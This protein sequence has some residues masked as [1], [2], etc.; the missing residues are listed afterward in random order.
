MATFAASP[1]RIM[2]AAFGCLCNSGAGAF[3]VDSVILDGEAASIAILKQLANQ[4]TTRSK[5]FF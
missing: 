2:E 1:S 4:T 5:P 3:V